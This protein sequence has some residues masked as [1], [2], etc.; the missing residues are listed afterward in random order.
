M[1]VETGH[2][3]LVLAF[4]LAVVQGVFPLI[5]ASRRDDRLMA[6]AAPAAYGQ[7]LLVLL[8]FLALMH[9]Y[10]TSDFSVKNVAINSHTLKPMLYKVAGVWGNHE[11]SILF[12]ALILA[13]FGGLVAL[14]GRNL[15]KSLHVRVLA[16]QGLI[17]VGFYLFLLL[18]S[19]PFERVFPVPL[20]GNGLNPLLQDPGLA[21]H[22]PFL[23][24][25]YVGLSVAFS[26]AV[27]A[28]LEGRVDPAWA[29][30]VRPWTL[31][32]WCF[33]TIGITLGS[34]WAYYELG[35]GGWWFWDPVENA[36]F[37]PWLVAT[38]LLHSAIVVEKRD[39]LK[40]WTI[41][42]AIIAF[43]FSL[44]GTFLTRSGVITSVHAFATDPERGVFILI[45]LLIV[46]GGSLLLYALRYDRLQPGG[47]FAPIS[48]E[49]ALVMNNM[50][51]TVGAATVLF[52][53]LYPLLLDALT[54]DKISV[55]A[56]YFEITL[57]SLMIP[58]VLIM[59]AGPFLRWKR[60]DLFGVVHRM[61]LVLFVSL[62]VMVAGYFIAHHDAGH[63]P[64]LTA[65]WLGLGIWLMLGTLAELGER[66]KLFK[67]PV[68]DS[69]RRLGRQTR[70]SWGMT[71]GHFGLSVM[72]LGI[73][74]TSSWQSE[75]LD[76]LVAGEK[77][78]IG[79]YELTFNGVRPLAGPNYTSLAGE[80]T[81]R[82]KNGD[83]VT[84]LLPES[85][86][87][88]SP[89]MTTTEA[90]IYARFFGDLFVA[91]G[92]GQGQNAAGQDRWSVRAYYKPLQFWLWGGAMIMVIG[93]LV[94]LSDRRF[95][96]GVPAGRKRTAATGKSEG[97]TAHAT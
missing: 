58:L 66:I 75:H 28:L 70:A 35:W 42:L 44:L 22:P 57:G 65:L 41:L 34:W 86:T 43:S 1:I 50:L 81:V 97:G 33:L 92:E 74:V 52:G 55:G 10:I 29:R 11:G 94:S 17:S 2:F 46:I 39:T 59:A 6:V 37:M 19:N 45:F 69:V 40:S 68:M 23:Y 71:L 53:T 84:Q 73:A 36:S 8:A 49:G 47:L 25:G 76:V 88:A 9:A 62:A 56:P 20:E 63:R 61:R 77:I 21:F 51:L 90:A 60:A 14:F 16:V 83:E 24:L 91:I 12:W 67:V 96:I 27:A 7:F 31:I 54:G 18:T 78:E 32:A 89:P 38:A 72:I 26:F 85:R 13:L 95:R 4:A 5:G 87:Y 3:A 15:P 64:L 82:D 93:G 80:F 48:R 30:W 79:G